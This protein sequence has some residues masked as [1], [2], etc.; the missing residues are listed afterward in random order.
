V[1]GFSGANGTSGFSGYSGYS[2]INGT[3]QMVYDQFTS[4]ASQTTF[5]TTNTYT[6]GKIEVFCQGVKMVNAVDV[7]VSN[8]TS[9]VF[10]TAPATSSRIDLVYPI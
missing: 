2:G 10:A 4:S 5:T 7:T 9:V 6:S 3:Q 1:S 8:G